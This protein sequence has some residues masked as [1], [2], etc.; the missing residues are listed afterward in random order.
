M[1]HV[2]SRAGGLTDLEA[3]RAFARSRDPGAFEVLLERYQ[4]MVLSTCLRVLG[5]RGHA[6]DATQETFLKLARH[7]GEISTNAGAWLHR[8]ATRTAIDAQ[9]RLRVRRDAE[10][11]A[12]SSS[13][14][15]EERTWREIEPL[16]DVALERLRDQDRD[17]LVSRFLLGRSQAVMAAEAGVNSGTMSR[18]IERALN[19]LHG[20]LRSQSV[21]IGTVSALGTAM[22]FAGTVAGRA[23][24]PSA[25]AAASL[26][27]IGLAAGAAGGSGSVSKLVAVSVAAVLCGGLVTAGVMLVGSGGSGSGVGSVLASAGAVGVAGPVARPKKA[28][29]GLTLVAQQEGGPMMQTMESDGSTIEIRLPSWNGEEDR[30]TLRVV[31]WEPGRGAKGTMSLRAEKVELMKGSR[32]EMLRDRAFEA[33]YEIDSLGLLRLSTRI[34]HNGEMTSLDWIGAPLGGQEGR[35]GRPFVGTWSEVGD[36]SMNVREDLVEVMSGG[37][38][39]FRFKVLSWEERN[40]ETRVA[41]ICVDSMAPMLVGKRMKLLLR[42]EDG[43]YDLAFRQWP[44][45]RLDEWPEGFEANEENSLNVLSFRRAK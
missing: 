31:D 39:V 24:M 43:R 36:W 16:V 35:G 18:R 12:A 7:A 4:R 42:V 19:R 38:A 37:Y 28:I 13:G 23:V 9:R 8:C 2:G 15:P 26:G 25:E 29:A 21:E 32:L 27:K 44:R 45:E 33:G 40:G 30:L 20:E 1:T 17:V 22:V 14:V 34:E 41:S 10:A 5:D 3:V 11:V 6:E